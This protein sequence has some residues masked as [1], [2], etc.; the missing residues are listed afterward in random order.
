MKILATAVLFILLAL[1][2]AQIFSFL[3]QEHDLSQTLADS[4]N[5]LAKAERDGASLSATMQF[6]GNPANLEKQLRA[7][8][9]YKKPGET[10]IVIVPETSSTRN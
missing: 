4:E 1:V 9:N 5:R 3:G 7:Q 10:M 8:F 2:G 6:L